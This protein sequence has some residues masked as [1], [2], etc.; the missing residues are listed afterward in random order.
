MNRKKLITTL[1]FGVILATYLTVLFLLKKEFNMSFWLSFGFIMASFVIMVASFLFVANE[2]RKRQ[3]VGMP[4][5]VLSSLYFAVEFVLGTIFMFFNL[6][7]VPVFIPQFVLFALFL[8]CYI[9]A[10]LSENNYKNTN[11]QK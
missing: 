2:N 9:P 11:S 1:I 6:T 4:V 3:V 7:F 5:T 8:I 10:M